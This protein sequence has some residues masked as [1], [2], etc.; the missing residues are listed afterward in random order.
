MTVG[1]AFSRV[2]SGNTHVST[3]ICLQYNMA[4]SSS[5]ILVIMSCNVS[6]MNQKQHAKYLGDEKISKTVH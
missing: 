5:V 4:Y 3:N 1:L 2:T 6:N